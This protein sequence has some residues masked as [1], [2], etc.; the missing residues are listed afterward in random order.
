VRQNQKAC[1][2]LLFDCAASTLLGFGKNNLGA[3]LGLTAVLHTW[4]QTLCEH[5]HLHFVV[6]GGG[7]SESGEEWIEAQK[8]TVR[9]VGLD[10][11]P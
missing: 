5:Y 7:L 11:M 9:Y 4:G 8:K 6:T 2:D 10:V 3:V 1:L